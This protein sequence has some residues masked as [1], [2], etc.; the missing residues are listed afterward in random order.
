VLA[1][2]AIVLP[3]NVTTQFLLDRHRPKMNL[4]TNRPSLSL[5]PWRPSPLR[6]AARTAGL[7]A[8]LTGLVAANAQHPVHTFAATLAVGRS[9][10]VIA[11]VVVVSIGWLAF[12]ARRARAV[13]AA[14]DPPTA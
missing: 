10:A 9:G 11:S 14:S 13:R 12:E 3:H 8:A 4:P 6:V 2:F 5:V 7:W 1:L